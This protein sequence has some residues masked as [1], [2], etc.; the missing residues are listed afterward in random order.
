MAGVAVGWGA[1][2]EAGSGM[3][4]DAGGT[5]VEPGQRKTGGRVIE[6][7]RLP[8][9]GIMA[10]SASVTNSSGGMVRALGA[11]EIHRMTGIAVGRCAAVITGSVAGRTGHGRMR[12]GQR[13]SGCSVIE[14]P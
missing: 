4:R 7:R 6:N 1:S 2:C 10:C 5:S 14:I 12:A 13:E 8:S 11:S 9:R 3:T